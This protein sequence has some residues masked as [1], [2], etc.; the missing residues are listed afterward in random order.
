MGTRPRYKF[1]VER[2]FSRS[3]DYGTVRA[4]LKTMGQVGY[5]QPIVARRRT[6]ITICTYSIPAV[7][8]IIIGLSPVWCHMHGHTVI[9]AIRDW[10]I[11]CKQCHFVRCC[12]CGS[13]FDGTDNDTTYVL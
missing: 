13:N 3:N 2:H 4:H 6:M 10:T 7:Q 9:A 1:I 11:H 12:L 5:L 8:S